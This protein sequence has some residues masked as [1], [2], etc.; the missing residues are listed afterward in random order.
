MTGTEV[1]KNDRFPCSI[2][3]TEQP[4]NTFVTTQS[5]I[6]PSASVRKDNEQPFCNPENRMTVI[7]RN[8]NI[9]NSQNRYIDYRTHRVGTQTPP[10]GKPMNWTVPP[11]RRKGLQRQTTKPL[12]LYN[13]ELACTLGI[14]IPRQSDFSSL[15]IG[16][17]TMVNCEPETHHKKRRTDFKIRRN[18]RKQHKF[19]KMFYRRTMLSLPSFSFCKHA[20]AHQM[21]HLPNSTHLFLFS[22]AFP[23]VRPKRLI[24][25]FAPWIDTLCVT[26]TLLQYAPITIR[27]IAYTSNLKTSSTNDNDLLSQFTARRLNT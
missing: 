25:Y 6:L 23:R 7:I 20:C 11:L 22:V 14:V 3:S 19:R 16:I 12:R 4:R 18:I 10:S 24:K 17:P 1:P 15:I 21:H 5:A 9:T 13:L 27:H 2:A 8:E 26:D